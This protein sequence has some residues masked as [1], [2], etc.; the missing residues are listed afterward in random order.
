M[1]SKHLRSCRCVV[2]CVLAIAC[3]SCTSERDASAG[4][5]NGSG[6]QTKVVTTVTKTLKTPDGR[7]RTY[8]IR[9][10]ASIAAGTRVP[11]LIALHGGVGSGKQFEDGSGFDAI[12]DKH[13]FIVV[14]PDG[15]G[16]GRNED[17]LRTWNGGYCC[18]PA[19]K[20]NV[21]DVDFIRR[22]IG[23]VEGEYSIDASRV[24]IAGHSNGGI[25]AYRLACELSDV[26]AA[27]GL[28]AGSLGVD[29]CAPTRPVS[30]I[31]IHGTADQN[32]P[33]NGGVGTNGISRI[34][35]RSAIEGIRTFAAVERVPLTSSDVPDPKNP[36]VV[37]TTWGPD[38]RG[39]EVQFVSVRGASHAWMGPM[40]QSRIGAR[41]TGK[42]YTRLNAS[43]TI[44]EFLAAHP[45]I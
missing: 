2:L 40:P 18:G 8:R 28:Q 11:L 39:T 29:A 44:W 25:M 7:R 3:L 22:L 10:P 12:A 15:V 13:R 26:I 30:L 4:T 21:D 17:R 31:H 23:V 43:E 19:V 24:F 33:I 9:V 5:H 32:H 36:D 41:L 45:R 20:K 37:R 38:A 1:N 14:Y 35:F 34:N 27:V 16:I 42:Q 6:S